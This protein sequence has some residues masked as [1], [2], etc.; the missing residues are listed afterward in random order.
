M[1]ITEIELKTNITG[2]TSSGAITV[3]GVTAT[4]GLSAATYTL[5]H[6]NGDDVDST[7]PAIVGETLKVTVTS[8]GLD[9]GKTV[10]Y[11]MNGVELGKVTGTATSGTTPITSNFAYVVKAADASL[12]VT[13]A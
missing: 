3:T 2:A 10:T 8:T 12:P 13:V 1:T 5:K 9:N 6:A 11:T 4:T 7:K